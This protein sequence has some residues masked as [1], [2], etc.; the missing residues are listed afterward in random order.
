M[1]S[2]TPD[3]ILPPKKVQTTTIFFSNVRFNGYDNRINGVNLE[4][5]DSF[6]II[7]V[8]E[9]HDYLNLS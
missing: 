5:P 1:P 4:K 9:R 2:A 6:D 8:Q 3:T 7:K